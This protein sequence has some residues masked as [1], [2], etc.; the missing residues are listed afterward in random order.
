LPKNAQK[1]S[2]DVKER[3]ENAYH[4]AALN[5]NLTMDRNKIIYDRNIKKFSYKVGDYVL[6]DHP[7]LKSG[8]SR[9]L[10]HK[11]YGPF[12]IKGLN[13]N[14][15]DYYI[16]RVGK[17]RSKIYHIH[18]N[19]LKSY[20]MCNKNTQDALSSEDEKLLCTKCKRDTGEKRRYIKNPQH[21]RWHKVG[22]KDNSLSELDVAHVSSNETSNDSSVDEEIKQKIKRKYKKRQAN[23]SNLQKRTRHLE[24][25]DEAAHESDAEFANDNLNKFVNDSTSI[26]QTVRPRGRPRK[27]VVSENPFVVPLQMAT[28]AIKMAPISTRPRRRL[29]PPDKFHF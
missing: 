2:D 5:R 25:S 12:V 22:E 9:G 4:Q 17:K 14:G 1:Y 28:P 19:R 26:K 6:C 29:K 23:A 24:L 18:Q 3:M 7:R 20:Y 16:A 27:T 15:V 8:L 10:A 11:Y 13:P 21:P